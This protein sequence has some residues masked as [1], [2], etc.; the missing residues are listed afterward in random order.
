MHLILASQVL[1]LGVSRTVRLTIYG[2]SA[3]ALKWLSDDN[4]ELLSTLHMYNS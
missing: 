1:L 2:L 3:E 4:T